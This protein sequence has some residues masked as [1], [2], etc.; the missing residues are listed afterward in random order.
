MEGN[1]EM[2]E[3][4]TG[5][6]IPGEDSPGEGKEAPPGGDESKGGEE[7]TDARLEARAKGR[8]GRGKQ[9]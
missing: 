2:T 1:K 7:S 4:N 5:T 8:G 3:E 6:N 9:T